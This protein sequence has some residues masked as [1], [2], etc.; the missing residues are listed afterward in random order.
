[1]ENM[2]L[3]DFALTDEV[4]ELVCVINVRVYV[5]TYAHTNT[6]THTHKHTHTCIYVYTYI[7][8]TCPLWLG[9]HYS[10]TSLPF[11]TVVSSH[12]TTHFTTHRKW[13]RSTP[14]QQSNRLLLWYL[15]TLPHTLPH[16]YRKWR[17]STPWQQ[18]SRSKSSRRYISN[19][20]CVSYKPKRCKLLHPK[21][22]TLNSEP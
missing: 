16:T 5:Y 8:R 3:F 19:V 4:L 9:P 21:R 1:M 10:F 22:C 12:F 13:R 20:W 18:T 17:R 7:H 15:V 14:W 11:N 2:A 6:H